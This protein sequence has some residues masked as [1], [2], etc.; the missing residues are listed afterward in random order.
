MSRVTVMSGRSWRACALAGLLILAGCASGSGGSARTDQTLGEATAGR[1][2]IEAHNT[3][4]PQTTVLLKYRAAGNRE[5]ILGNV[6]PNQTETFVIDTSSLIVGFVLIAERSTRQ[7]L[8]SDPIDTISR[9]VIKWNMGT[10][11]V[12]VD[13][14]P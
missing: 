9:A 13:R 2:A 7:Q 3:L 1:V 12:T 5:R 10:N 11:L 6:G 14:L 8:V 4:T